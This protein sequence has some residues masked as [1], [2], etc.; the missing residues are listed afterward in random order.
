MDILLAKISEIPDFLE[1]T[2]GEFGK[3]NPPAPFP[4]PGKGEPE[5][6]SPLRG[7]VGEGSDPSV[8]SPTVSL[9]KSGI[10]K[11]T[12]HQQLA[13]RLQAVHLRP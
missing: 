5:S 3:P 1:D 4:L 8:N 12:I 11:T 6:P 9:E 10:F 2:A 7:G 13:L